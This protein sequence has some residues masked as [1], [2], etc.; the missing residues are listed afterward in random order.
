MNK[1]KKSGFDKFYW[2]C[3]ITIVILKAFG[4]I[5]ASW[6]VATAMFWAP[7]ALLGIFF[8]ILMVLIGFVYFAR[9]VISLIKKKKGTK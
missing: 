7:Y 9:K 6:W 8:M 2:G 1:L 3:A 4:V 5:K